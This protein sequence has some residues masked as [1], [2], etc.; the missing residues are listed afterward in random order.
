LIIILAVVCCVGIFFY[1]YKYQR[2]E[3]IEKEVFT[4]T[5]TTITTTEIVKVDIT[6]QRGEVVVADKATSTVEVKTETATYS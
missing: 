5:D 2:E 3:K 1:W 4:A 6:T